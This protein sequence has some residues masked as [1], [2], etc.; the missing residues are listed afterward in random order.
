VDRPERSH[1]EPI[2]AAI[3][4]LRRALTDA[5][6]GCDRALFGRRGDVAQGLRRLPAV[7]ER[8]AVCTARVQAALERG[9]RHE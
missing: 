5:A 6:T 8:L 7:L 9:G 3:H 2:E 4:A 1:H